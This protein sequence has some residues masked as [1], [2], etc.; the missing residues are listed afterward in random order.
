VI[1]FGTLEI[2]LSIMESFLM[3]PSLLK[4]SNDSH[5]TILLPSSLSPPR[6]ESYGDPLPSATCFKINFDTTIIDH[7]SVQAAVCR[8]SKGKIVK[9]FSQVRPP[10]DPTFGEALAAGRAASLKLKNFF[11]DGDSSIVISSLQQP[12]IVLD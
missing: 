8:N 4:T 2:K 5:W 6:V 10:C 1:C 9:A 12:A 7:F 11:L 3:P